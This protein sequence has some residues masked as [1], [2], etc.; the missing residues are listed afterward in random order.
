[1]IQISFDRY[2]L[3]STTTRQSFAIADNK[4]NVLPADG[5][6]TIY[7]PVARTITI[8]G[9]RGPGVEWLQEG[10]EYKLVLFVPPNDSTD[11]A[12]LRAID[13]APLDKDQT[14]TFV[15]KARKAN[16]GGPRAVDPP[17]NFCADVLPLFYNK[18]GDASCH[19]PPPTTTGTQPRASLILSTSEGVRVT[20]IN[21]VAQGANTGG[22]SFDPQPDG[23]VFGVDMAI[24][25]AP[26]GQ[27]GEPGASWL[28][29]KIEMAPHP[30]TDAGAASN[31]LC[32][33]PASSDAVLTPG[34][35]YVPRAPIV[36]A[37]SNDERE[38]LGDLML[39]A[40]MPYPQSAVGYN[41]QPLTFE[42]RERVRRWIAQGAPTPECGGCGIPAVASDAG[43]DA[44]R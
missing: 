13:R 2:L 1:M 5:F 28:M 44:G 38:R 6:Q 24:I 3:P 21:R 19:G 18:C 40:P 23:P 12:G 36:R 17:V 42:E 14:R 10:L 16:G 31:A 32:T 43:A 33:P 11:I 22:R 7:D 4:N 37:A 30:V 25:K 34:D 39:G 26:P 9:P 29:Y 27:P 20:A 8:A 15:F 41:T 35:P